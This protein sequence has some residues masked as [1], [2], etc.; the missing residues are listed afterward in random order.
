WLTRDER[1]A[2]S[3]LV[4]FLV[5]EAPFV[6][7]PVLVDV[8]IVS[9]NQAPDFLRAELDLV[10]TAGRAAGAD[11]RHHREL[12]SAHGE[13][14]ILGRERTDGAYVDGVDRVRVVELLSGRRG[15][16]F[17]IATRRHGELM[18]PRHLVAHA[19]ATCAQDAALLIENDMGPD[20]D[21]FLLDDLV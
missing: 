15:Q 21:D 11:G 5:G 13:A 1:R 2:H 20:V 6:A 8:G 12:P 7:H 18:L 19:D 17:A 16:D 9:R 10:V 4:D 3:T 14:E